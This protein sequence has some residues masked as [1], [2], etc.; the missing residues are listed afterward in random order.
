M[1]VMHTGEEF[2][3]DFFNVVGNQGVLASRVVM[4]PAHVKRMLHALSENM[5]IY[6]EKFGPVTAAE[7]PKEKFGF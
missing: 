2:V 3:M 5:K 4:N 7:Q 6:E 1:Q